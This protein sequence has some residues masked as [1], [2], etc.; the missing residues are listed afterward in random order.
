MTDS[1]L[2][3]VGRV[4][5]VHLFPEERLHLLEF[6]RGLSAEQW[7]LPTVCRGRSVGD[8]ARHLLGDDLGRLSRV[9]DGFRE[10]SQAEPGEDLV[11]LVNRLNEQWVTTLRRRSS[12]VVC[13]LVAHK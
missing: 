3:P 4:E 13:D 1:G 12:R 8:I 6:L 10:P 9:R 7:T 11:A 2:R 5:V